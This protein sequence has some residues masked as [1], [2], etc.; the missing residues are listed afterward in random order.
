MPIRNTRRPSRSRRRRARTTRRARRATSARR[1]STGK[2]RRASCA[3]SCRGTAGFAHVSCLAEQAKILVA[4]AEENNLDRKALAGEVWHRS[5][6]CASKTTTASCGARS[7]GRA[8]RR[9]WGGRRRTIFGC[10]AMG[11]LGNG[12]SEASHHEDALSVR[13]AEL[14]MVRR[15]GASE[16]T[17]S[18]RRTIL[19]S[20][21]KRSDGLKRPAHAARRILRMF[22]EELHGEEHESTLIDSQPTTPVALIELEEIFDADDET[23]LCCCALRERMPV[24]RRVL[25]GFG[26]DARRCW[27]VRHPLTT[28]IEQT[29]QKIRAALRAR[30]QRAV[31]LQKDRAPLKRLPVLLRL[32]FR[33]VGRPV[34]GGSRTPSPPPY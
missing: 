16:Q 27:A 29:L 24:A 15:I 30:E 11:Q 13:E 22:G 32:L 2:R 23:E 17:C 34:L 9:T 31:K 25:G 20:R 4:E 5:T 10:M 7:G 28:E 8:G 3:C 19:R 18:S 12:L 26:T 14:S 21:I 1:P 33:R 6:V